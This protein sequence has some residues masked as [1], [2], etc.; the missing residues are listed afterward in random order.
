[1]ANKTTL[2]V[3]QHGLWGTV[4]HMDYLE[5]QILEK[6]DSNS[7]TTVKIKIKKKEVK[8]RKV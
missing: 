7:I 4:S 8:G 3:L 5:K 2:I 1:M 6:L